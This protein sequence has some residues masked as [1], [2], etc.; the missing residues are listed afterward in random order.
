VPST[1]PRQNRFAAVD[2]LTCKQSTRTLLQFSR[3]WILSEPPVVG[4]GTLLRIAEQLFVET[5]EVDYLAAE[6]LW[7]VSRHVC[8]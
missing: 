4:L 3:S 7:H 1:N 2:E 8:R 5:P 6:S